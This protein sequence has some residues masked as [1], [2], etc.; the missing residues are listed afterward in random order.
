M[1]DTES[2]IELGIGLLGLCDRVAV[3]YDNFIFEGKKK[4]PYIFKFILSF[5]C[6]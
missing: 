6:R 1:L 3:F 5:V 2:H 4:V